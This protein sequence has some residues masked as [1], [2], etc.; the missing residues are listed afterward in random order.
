MGICARWAHTMNC[1]KKMV[2]MQ[3]CIACNTKSS[4][5]Y[6]HIAGENSE[7]MTIST[8][9]ITESINMVI[10]YVTTENIEQARTIGRTLL[11][12]RVAACINILP[13]ME[14]HY[15]WH[16]DIAVS[17]ECVLLIKTAEHLI[18][19][20]RIRIAQLHSYDV[21]CILTVPIVSGNLPYMA[22]LHEQIA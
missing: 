8:E 22:W 11:A 2:Y 3:N 1:L 18:E 10:L 13:E 6:E 19:Q 9:S 12:E 17:Q 20:A 4:W 5:R 7:S 14:S 21:P 15:H 16:G